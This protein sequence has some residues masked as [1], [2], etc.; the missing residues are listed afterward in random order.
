MIDWHSH[1]LPGMDDGSRNKQE[2]LALLNMLLSQGVDTVVATPHYYANDESVESFLERRR[3][4]MLETENVLFENAPR[5]IPGAEVRYYSGISRMDNLKKLRIGES[6]LLLLEMPCETFTEYT[7]RELLELS[8]MPGITLMLAHIERSMGFQKKSVMQRLYESGILMQVNAG[9]FDGF[10]T[11]RKA[12][13]M[14]WSGELHLIG[15]DCHN[16]YSRA[17]RIKKA[18]D[19]IKRRLGEEFISDMNNYG[20]SMLSGDSQLQK[21]SK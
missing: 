7:V 13:S 12:V 14:L 18:Y 6:K 19:V 2:T 20:Y 1:I 4:A 3:M 9:F 17:P 21:I 10:F 8:G 5:I 11:Q 15:S 16:T